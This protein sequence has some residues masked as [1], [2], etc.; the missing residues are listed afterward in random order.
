MAVTTPVGAFKKQGRRQKAGGRR[1]EAG[2]KMIWLVYFICRGWRA[3]RG[4]LFRNKEGGRRG[5]K[6]RGFSKSF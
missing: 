5:K 2:G 3:A 1:Q 6:R 4:G